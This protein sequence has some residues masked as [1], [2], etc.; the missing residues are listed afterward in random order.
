MDLELAQLCIEN[1]AC[2]TEGE[3]NEHFKPDRDALMKDFPAECQ[4]L[5]AWNITLTTLMTFVSTMKNKSESLGRLDQN[6]TKDL[7]CD[8]NGDNIV[9]V[10]GEYLFND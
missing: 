10:V 1:N 5:G 2:F 9:S 8:T 3:L 4:R 6:H 7:S